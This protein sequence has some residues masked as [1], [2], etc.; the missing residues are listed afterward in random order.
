ML[1]C[2]SLAFCLSTGPNHLQATDI[3]SIEFK[4][5]TET[6]N[7]VA[8]S[9]DGTKI[10]TASVDKTARIWEAESGRELRKLEGHT[11]EIFSAFFSPD[12]KSV[13]TASADRT[14]RI[15]NVES[16]K[17]L[18]VFRARDGY[19]FLSPF[20]VV[21]FASFSPDGK[22]IVVAL[23]KT[24][25]IWN[26]ETKEERLQLKGHT[27]ISPP[28]VRQSYWIASAVF[29][30]DGQTIATA[31]FADT[32]VRIWDAKSGKELRRLKDTFSPITSAFFSPDGKQIVASSYAGVRVWDAVS[33][34]VLQEFSVLKRKSF[35]FA[36]F[37]PDGAKIAT[38]GNSAVQVWD[39]KSEEELKKLEGYSGN[40]QSVAFSPDGKRI[41]APCL[42]GTVKIW[43]LEQ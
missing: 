35:Y 40:V 19:T 29:S 41:V 39:A 43:W 8:F 22:E 12:G 10:V 1:S 42:D 37:S 30:P 24:A 33:S 27:D 11:D 23:E 26:V 18:K 32:F 3:P 31:G 38:S 13:V 9:P 4:G 25:R 16:G 36:E 21:R 15:F 2:T 14:A 5:H 34:K 6:V 7:F 20:S 17:T 28:G